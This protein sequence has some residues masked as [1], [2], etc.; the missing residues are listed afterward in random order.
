MSPLNTSRNI[1]I[2]D[3]LV[4]AVPTTQGVG[5][6]VGI[7][8]SCFLPVLSSLAG[9]QLLVSRMMRIKTNLPILIAMVAFVQLVGT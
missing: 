9:V 6:G 5:V 1:T 3:P 8:A 2:G 4:S 7:I